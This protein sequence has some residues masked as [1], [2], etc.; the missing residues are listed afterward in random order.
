MSWLI[1]W[2]AISAQIEGLL[3]ASRFYIDSLR[4]ASR[5]INK[6]GDFYKVGDRELLPHIK[7]ICDTLGK[8]RD[9]H[10]ESIPTGAAESLDAMLNKIQ[11]SFPNLRDAD[12]FKHVHVMVTLLVSF[13]AEFEYHLSDTTAVAKRLSERAF[14]HLQRSIVVDRELREKWIEAFRAGELAC[15]K[16][17]AV[18]LLLHGIWAFKVNAAGERTDLVFDEPVRDFYSIER[19]AESLVLTE[20]KCVRSP[21]KTEAIAT[22]A[23]K[24]AARYTVGALGGLVELIRYR[25]IVLVSENTLKLPEN[26]SE[27]EVEYR[28]VNVAVN[29]K[30]PSKG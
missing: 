1:E 16:L 5:A 26:H 4:D 29:P 8:F 18:H 25:F 3:E 28:H 2:K 30:P 11:E 27:N 15:E 24:Q 20:W 7:K 17:G 21:A 22:D 12:A 23:R 19:V 9:A 13:R 10:K 14:S 6:V